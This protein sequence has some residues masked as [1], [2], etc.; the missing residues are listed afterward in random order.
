[1]SEYSFCESVHAGPLA[2][3]H[4][5]KLTDQGQ[6]FGG[7][8]DTPSLC[9]RVRPPPKSNGWDLK[10]PIDEMTLRLPHGRGGICSD[11][12]ALYEK[13]VAS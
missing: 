5:R 1:M 12:A 11:C 3:W 13:A 9:G 4:I 2:A 6:K 7:G 10:V 8:I